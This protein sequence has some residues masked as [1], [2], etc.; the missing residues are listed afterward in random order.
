MVAILFTYAM[1]AFGAAGR[2]PGGKQNEFNWK[3]FM[4]FVSFFGLATMMYSL[5]VR[6][7]QALV[8]FAPLSSSGIGGSFTIGSNSRLCSDKRRTK[9]SS[10][11]V[12]SCKS[13]P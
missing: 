7:T 11:P 10:T 5:T 1:L 12:P 8:S 13:D 2:A 9:L 6:G 4:G 3:N